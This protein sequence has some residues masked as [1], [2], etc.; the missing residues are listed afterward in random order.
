MV[1]AHIK[2]IVA[3]AASWRLSSYS[4]RLS[5][6]LI[7]L[8]QRIKRHFVNNIIKKMVLL[9]VVGFLIKIFGHVASDFM[10]LPLYFSVSGRNN[11]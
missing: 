8:P 9:Y 6:L 1:E 10:D 2:L 3:R 11:G 4:K 7:H 5:I